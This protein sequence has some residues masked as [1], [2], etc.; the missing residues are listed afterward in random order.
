MF[1]LLK[2]LEVTPANLTFSTAG[3]A[4]PNY[5]SATTYSLGNRVFLPVDGKTYI[6]VQ[7]PALDKIPNANPLYWTIADPSNRWAMFDNS[8]SF[9]TR[10]TT[11]LAVTI[12]LPQRYNSLS[13]HGLVGNRVTVTQTQGSTILMSETKDLL[14]GSTSWYNYFYE[15][16][17]QLH[18]CVFTNLVPAIGSILNISIDGAIVACSNLSLGNSFE[19]GE[20]QYGASTSILDYSKKETTSAGVLKL[21]KGSFS[22]RMSSTIVLTR[23]R[24]NAVSSALEGVRGTAATWVGVS[25]STEYEPMTIFG[26][27]R[28]F[29]IEVSNYSHHTCSLEVEGLTTIQ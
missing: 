25:D 20:S 18:T 22:K 7:A 12:E 2:P 8:T 1:L 23:A 17:E 21:S 9:A 3:A 14:S 15:P 19:L 6:C 11:L 28:D 10:G 29:N 27:F 16:K 13:L 26:F 24:Y 5:S 4:D